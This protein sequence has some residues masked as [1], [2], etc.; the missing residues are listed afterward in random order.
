VAA[1]LRVDGAQLFVLGRQ[2]KEQLERRSDD[3]RSGAAPSSFVGPHGCSSAHG[4]LQLVRE[5]TGILME[6]FVSLS[7][8]V[9]MEYVE[10]GNTDGLPVVF[11]HGVTDSW[12]SFE[13]VLPLL[14]ADV[15][16]FAVSARGHG[17]S[18]RPERGYLLSDMS[19]DLG[20]FMDAVGLA[21]A[22]IVG[23]SM[24]A[25]VAQRFVVDHPDRVRGLVLMGAFASLFQDPGLMDFYQSAIAPLEDPI[26]AAFARDWQQSTLAR[27]MAPEHLDA[28]VAE[29][30]KVPA[31]IWREAF[32]G[33]LDTPDFTS[34]LAR[35]S[36]PC[37]IMWGDKDTYALRESQDR[38]LAAVSGARLLVYEGAGHTFHWEDPTRFAADLAAFLTT[39]MGA[40]K[41]AS[42]S[43]P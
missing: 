5:A 36:A 4:N 18:S 19:R 10:Q 43:R 30:L 40:A 33:F 22:V 29:T 6:K 9:R 24:G 14:A 26:D 27:P 8:G 17:E 32:Q 7:T 1:P 41:P 34:E 2:G 25:M 13:R 42:T 12:R 20:A 23:H 11:L 28:V 39:G 37:V 38:L 21:Q 3:T 35:V 16:A 31:R 15:H